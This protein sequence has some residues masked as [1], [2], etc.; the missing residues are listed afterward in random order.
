MDIEDNL[1]ACTTANSTNELLNFLVQLDQIEKE[2]FGTWV[3]PADVIEDPDH[4]NGPFPLLGKEAFEWFA[5]VIPSRYSKDNSATYEGLPPPPI[6]KTS[7]FPFFPR[8]QQLPFLNYQWDV[9]SWG[10]TKFAAFPYWV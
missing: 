6:S 3:F 2:K 5:N 4:N 1:T 10:Q 8:F 9:A 7:K